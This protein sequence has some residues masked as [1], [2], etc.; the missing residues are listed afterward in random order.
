MQ[1]RNQ[2]RAK[3][4]YRRRCA[5]ETPR[6]I[7]QDYGLSRERIRQITERYAY[8]TGVTVPVRLSASSKKREEVERKKVARQELGTRMLA[9]ES[10]GLT[11]VEIAEKLGI[12]R[13]VVAQSLLRLRGRI[14]HRS[15]NVP[16]SLVYKWKDQFAQGMTHDRIAKLSGYTQATVSQHLR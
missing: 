15:P 9:L 1:V 8:Q 14:K 16:I 3:E 12:T 13:G 7:G 5:G 2:E 11:Q 6:E 10:A 4:M